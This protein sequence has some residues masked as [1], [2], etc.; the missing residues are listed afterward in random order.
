MSHSLD[1]EHSFL[2]PSAGHPRV[3]WRPDVYPGTGEN[4]KVRQVKFQASSNKNRLVPKEF[5]SLTIVTP[6]YFV[7]LFLNFTETNDKNPPCV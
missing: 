1:S 4:W 3:T 2:G 6:F 7:T 5:S